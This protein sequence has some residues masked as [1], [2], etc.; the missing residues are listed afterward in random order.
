MRTLQEYVGL[1]L[2]FVLQR[3]LYVDIRAS[4]ERE[5]TGILTAMEEDI[6]AET[7]QRRISSIACHAHTQLLF[8]FSI[9]SFFSLS[10]LQL[11]WKRVR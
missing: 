3:I 2:V 1:D 8:F 9:F 11:R 10:F 4:A 6:A 7:W 5:Y